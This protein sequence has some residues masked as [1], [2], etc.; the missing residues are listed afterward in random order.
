MRTITR[1]KDTFVKLMITQVKAMEGIYMLEDVLNEKVICRLSDSIDITDIVMDEVG[2]PEEN[3]YCIV[4]KNSKCLDEDLEP[5]KYSR[6]WVF[7]SLLKLSI[8][9][10]KEKTINRGVSK[11]YARMIDHALHVHDI[12]K[13]EELIKGGIN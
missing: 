2:L 1:I 3:A 11:L 4:S 9:N 7:D 10:F 5:F 13:H 12:H 6:E 8:G